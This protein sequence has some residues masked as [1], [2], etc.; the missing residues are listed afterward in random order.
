MEARASQARVPVQTLI[1]FLETGDSIDDL[2]RVY[3]YIPREQVHAFLELSQSCS[4]G[5]RYNRIP[6]GWQR[7][8]DHVL[9]PRVQEQ[10]DV[11]VTIDGG[12][13]H[14]HNLKKLSLGIAIVHVSKTSWSFYRPLE[15]RLKEAVIAVKPGQ[16]IHVRSDD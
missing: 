3:P 8:K 2:L 1:D 14:E 7:L 10:F 11:L 9:L 13:E 4:R 6:I 5:M 15:R 16:V 12:F